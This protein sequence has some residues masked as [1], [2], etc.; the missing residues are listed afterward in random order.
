M[1]TIKRV[2]GM[3]RDELVHSGRVRCMLAKDNFVWSSGGDQKKNSSLQLWD[4][5]GGEV[6][7]ASLAAFGGLLFRGDCTQSS[8]NFIV[9]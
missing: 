3:E 2:Y 1:D 8:D 6:C 9:L 7:G 4:L 5:F